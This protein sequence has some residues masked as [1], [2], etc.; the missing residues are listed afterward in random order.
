MKLNKNNHAIRKVVIKMKRQT[1]EFKKQNEAIVRM[2][3]ATIYQPKTNFKG[4]SVK[5]YEDKPKNIVK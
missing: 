2:G 5:W 4:G 3:R 1:I